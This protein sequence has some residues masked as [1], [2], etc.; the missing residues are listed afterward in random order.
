MKEMITGGVVATVF[1][2]IVSFVVAFGISVGRTRGIIT[3]DNWDARELVSALLSRW[4]PDEVAKSAKPTWMIERAPLDPWGNEVQHEVLPSGVAEVRSWGEDGR[5]YTGD[6]IYA[7][8][9]SGGKITL[10]MLRMV[11]PGID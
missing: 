4:T 1:V 2:S 9:D 5:Q 6:D 3:D 8:R 7:Q 10:Y 11:R